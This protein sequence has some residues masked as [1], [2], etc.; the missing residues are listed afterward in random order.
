MENITLQFILY[1]IKKY[2]YP[3]LKKLIAE[4]KIRKEHFKKYLSVF[5]KYDIDLKEVK[6][7]NE[8]QETME[9]YFFAFRTTSYHGEEREDFLRLE[10]IIEANFS[11]KKLK[12]HNG[13]DVF[14]KRNE[15]IRFVESFHNSNRIYWSHH[16]ND[17]NIPW[18]EH[19]ITKYSHIWHWDYFYENNAIPWSLSLIDKNIDKI[20]WG[21]ALNLGKIKWRIE[22]VIKYQDKLFNIPTTNWYEHNQQNIGTVISSSPNIIWTAELIKKYE[23]RWE[24]QALVLNESV[25]WTVDKIE[26]F[27]SKLNFDL[28]SGNK[29]VEWSIELIE[30][31]FCRWNW[32]QLSANPNLPWS[33]EFLLKYQDYFFG[34]IRTDVELNSKFAFRNYFKEGESISIN[35]GISW[36]LK[37]VDQFIDRINLL[38]I[39][40]YAKSI[41]PEIFIKYKVCFDKSYVCESK[42]RKQSDWYDFED[43]YTNG[44]QNINK[45][46]SIEL[47]QKLL[48]VLNNLKTTIV[49]S[50]G[51]A[52]E[53]FTYHDEEIQVIYCF[54]IYKIK[55]ASVFLEE[56]KVNPS[57]GEGSIYNKYF[58]NEHIWQNMIKIYFESD[59]KVADYLDLLACES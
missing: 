28:L 4:K 52:R 43:I 44:W 45:N 46:T 24:W 20:D 10:A 13:E 37:M 7:N 57:I 22:D 8:Y 39:A 59:N 2:P 18:T 49:V 29:N 41:D 55:V 1:I 26:M 17:S 3:I 48:S 11:M 34:I 38:A 31:Y 21:K 9:D 14:V 30:K 40:K 51:N 35:R 25:F 50:K 56:M 33:Y 23:E 19:I 6:I 32:K 27:E 47:D 54:S 5:K 42:S 12:Q 16:C 15:F 58:I 36:T 53:G